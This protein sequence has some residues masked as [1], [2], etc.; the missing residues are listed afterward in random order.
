MTKKCAQ[1]IYRT[2]SYFVEERED[3]ASPIGIKGIGEIGITGV[4]AALANAVHNAT[5]I[6]FRDLPMTPDK[7]ILAR[8]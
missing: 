2:S 6:R 3:Y 7:L 8:A 5:G 1:R 4:A